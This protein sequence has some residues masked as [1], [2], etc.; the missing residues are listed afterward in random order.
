MFPDT[1]SEWEG[2]PSIIDGIRHPYVHIVSAPPGRL[3]LLVTGEGTGT[4]AYGISARPLLYW[5][6]DE[7]EYSV[8][9]HGLPSLAYDGRTYIKRARH[10][11][12][13]RIYGGKVLQPSFPSVEHFAFV[14]GDDCV[15]VLTHDDFSVAALA[16]KAD[17]KE[18]VRRVCEGIPAALID[19][20]P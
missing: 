18:W 1:T 15:E 17:S 7:F 11:H 9:G 10:S 12:L 19:Q 8:T 6:V 13:L 16:S 2:Y 5:V 4:E 20:L 3:N 14:G